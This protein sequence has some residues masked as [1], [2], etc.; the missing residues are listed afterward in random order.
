MC[1]RDSIEVANLLDQNH[2]GRQNERLANLKLMIQ[3]VEAGV[4]E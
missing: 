2:D 4:S 1:I 3:K